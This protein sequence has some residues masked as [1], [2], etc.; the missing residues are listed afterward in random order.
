[1]LR[2][3]LRVLDRPAGPLVAALRPVHRPVRLG[4]PDLARL[5]VQ[6]VG[7]AV[8]VAVDQRPTHPA[9]DLLVDQDVLVD[10]VVVP[11]VVRRHLVGP[12]RLTR[13]GVARPDRHRPLVVARPLIR[14]PGAGV[15]RAVVEEVQ[16]GVVRVPAP[17]RAAAPL[18]LVAGPRGHAEVLA[19]VVVVERLEVRADAD[20]AVRARAVH[21]PDLLAGV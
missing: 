14:V 12:A 5:P 3:L 21:A 15:A 11:R 20:L 16:L 13:I 7:E 1:L 10:A 17:R 8:A 19:L 18:P 6:R 4:D 2:P 9:V